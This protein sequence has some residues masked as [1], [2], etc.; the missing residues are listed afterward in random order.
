MLLYGE[1]E[2]QIRDRTQTLTRQ[3]AGSLSDPFLVA[4]LGRDR[5]S[6]IPGEM[7][8]LSLIGGRRVVI[9]RDATDAILP[10]VSAALA[11]PGEALLIIEGPGLGKGKLRSYAEA[12][13]HG[14][15]LASYVEEGATLQATIAKMLV[16]RNLS[17]EPDAMALLCHTLAADRAVLRGEI[18]KLSL[19]AE[20]GVSLD[21]DTIRICAGDIATG[22]GDDAILAMVAGDLAQGDAAVEAAFAD[23]LN[24]VSLLRTALTLLQKLHQAKLHIENGVLPSE[25]VRAIRPPIFY[26]NVSMVTRSLAAWSTDKLLRMI[27]EARQFELACKQTGSV[28][29]LLARRFLYRIARSGR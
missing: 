18:E 22:S 27:E 2:G 24:G 1:D 16:E 11:G 12:A 28:P 3:I 26:K 8:A 17:I 10:F 23:G 19:L 25:A 14:V 20:P 29:D 5:W 7:S 21:A 6:Q 9:A 15:A 13:S 4:E